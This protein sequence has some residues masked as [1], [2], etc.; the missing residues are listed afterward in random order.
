M[1]ATIHERSKMG[2]DVHISV[3]LEALQKELDRGSPGGMEGRLFNHAK[4]GNRGGL[5]LLIAAKVDVNNPRNEAGKTALM[6][7]A[8]HGQPE[9]IALLLEAGADINARDRNGETALMGATL[10][11][12]FAC[13]KLLLEAGADVNLQDEEGENA[14]MKAV[15]PDGHRALKPARVECAKLLIKAGADVNAKDRAG[16]TALR[17]AQYSHYGYKDCI[18]PLKQAGAIEEPHQL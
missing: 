6:A 5:Q 16:S 11:G 9:C 1:N 15:S 10:N 13:V 4:T 7:A 3:S 14:L 18:Q 12:H 17:R 8:L 2:T